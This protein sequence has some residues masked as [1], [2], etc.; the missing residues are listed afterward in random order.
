MRK[1]RRVV[2]E[3]WIGGVCAGVAYSLGAPA[4]LVRLVW[5]ILGFSY[6]V[7]ILPYLLLWVFMPEWDAT[8]ADYAER[9]GG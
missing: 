2:G 6:G 9:A 1:L 7:G 3:K 4:W 8:P 5:A